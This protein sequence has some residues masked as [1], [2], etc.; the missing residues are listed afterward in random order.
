VVGVRQICRLISNAN[1]VTIEESVPGCGGANG[2]EGS[3][4]DG[5][6]GYVTVGTGRPLSSDFMNLKPLRPSQ[7]S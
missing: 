6:G 3:T 5:T 7:V 1:T 2:G 4:D